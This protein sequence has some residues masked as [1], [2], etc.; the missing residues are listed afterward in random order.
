[1]PAYSI[2]V[3][4][5]FTI[6]GMGMIVLVT[7]RSKEGKRINFLGKPTI[8][9]FFFYTGKTALFLSWGLFL[10]KA[11]VPGLHV[12]FA[13][14]LTSWI[15]AVLMVIATVI[16]LVAFVN[17]GS[18]LRVG[19]PEEE[20]TLKTSGLY[21]FTRNPIYLGVF[22]VNIASVL[23]FPSILNLLF[24]F[25]GIMIHHQIILGEEK[26]LSGRFGESWDDYR[27]KVRRYL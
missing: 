8:D 1:M 10:F 7:A 5:C 6:L 25:Y 27:R 13:N 21:R 26:F 3:L 15:A 9:R 14:P 11:I 4:A 17:L 22:L 16:L 18:S 12:V 23:F 19:L 2:I 20:T 24:A